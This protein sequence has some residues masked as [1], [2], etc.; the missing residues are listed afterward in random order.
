M[1]ILVVGYSRSGT[2]LVRKLIAAHPYVKGILH[3]TMILIANRGVIANAELIY[4]YEGGEPIKMRSMC[5]VE[6]DTWGEKILYDYPCIDGGVVDALDYCLFWNELFAPNAAIINVLR[7]PLDVILSSQQKRGVSLEDTV[8]RYKKHMPET[9]YNIFD[10]PNSTTIRFEE[11]LSDT[12]LVLER[13]FDKCGLDST[14]GQIKHSISRARPDIGGEV[15]KN[16]A[17]SHKERYRE[18]DG[19]GLEDII[20]NLGYG[21]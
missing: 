5:D 6:E 11:L 14:R 7:Y 19:F 9:F 18:L 1:R 12:M 17:Y 21:K 4:G 20:K 13:V 8:K 2:T 3:E 10:L 15:D 16:V